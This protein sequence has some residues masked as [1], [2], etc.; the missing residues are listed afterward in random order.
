MVKCPPGTVTCHP[1]PYVMPVAGLVHEPVV[2]SLNVEGSRFVVWP[3]GSIWVARV[4][5]IAPD[6][7]RMKYSM[8]CRPLDSWMLNQSHPA[9]LAKLKSPHW[10]SI[11]DSPVTFT[12]MPWSTIVPVES[13]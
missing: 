2:V 12:G 5:T 7:F 10:W 3:P 6:E 9:P 8:Y 1:E 4:C 13:S 11:Q